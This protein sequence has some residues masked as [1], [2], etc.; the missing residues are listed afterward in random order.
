MWETLNAFLDFKVDPTIVSVVNV[1]VL[2]EKFFR[3]VGKFDVDVFWM[4]SGRSRG[5]S[6]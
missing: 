3:D 5:V 2:L 6:R 1:I 4:F